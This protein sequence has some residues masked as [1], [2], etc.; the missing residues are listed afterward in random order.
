MSVVELV[1]VFCGRRGDANQSDRYMLSTGHSSPCMTIAR[2]YD[3]RV[4]ILNQRK[5]SPPHRE[6]GQVAQQSPRVKNGWFRQPSQYG[7]IWSFL[8]PARAP[9][10]A[11]PK[12]FAGRCESRN[13]APGYRWEK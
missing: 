1:T 7:C 13:A 3:E 12:T 10:E 2:L 6:L 9:G 5:F 8:P 4:S 11:Y